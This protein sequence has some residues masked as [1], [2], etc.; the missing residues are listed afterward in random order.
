MKRKEVEV[1]VK[2]KLTAR[3]YVACSKHTSKFACE[4]LTDGSIDEIDSVEGAKHFESPLA[5]MRW[6]GG[7]YEG[8]N[9]VPVIGYFELGKPAKYPDPERVFQ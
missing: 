4:G 3:F 7:H 2:Q 5:I 8:Y 1:K 6:M 9:P